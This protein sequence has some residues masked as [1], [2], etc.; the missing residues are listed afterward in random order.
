MTAGSKT[1]MLEWLDTC[2]S[3]SKLLKERVKQGFSAPAAVAAGTQT[4]GVGRLGRFWISESGNLHLS[5]ALPPGVIDAKHLASLP[6]ICGVL[7]AEWIEST[8]ALSICIKWPNDLFLDGKKVGGILCEA[9]YEGAEF[10]GVILGIGINLMAVPKVS[11]LKSWDYLPGKLLWASGAKIAPR[12]IAF[13]LTDHFLKALH[14]LDFEDILRRRQRFSI[15]SGHQWIKSKGALTGSPRDQLP[16]E[17]LLDRG[18][19]GT[20][21]LR[22]EYGD[23]TPSNTGIILVNS[24]ANEYTW[25]IAKNGKSVVADV[26]NSMTKLAVAANDHQ[27][28]LDTV[29]VG[30]EAIE[31]LLKNFED[32]DKPAVIHAV[33]V[34]PEGLER[35]RSLAS[36]SGLTVREVQR[37][38]VALLKSKYDLQVIGMDRFAALEA[39]LNRQRMNRAHNPAMVVSLGTATTVDIIDSFGCHLGGYIV[40]GPQ[41]ALEAVSRRGRNL[42]KDLRISDAFSSPESAELY[43]TSSAQAMIDGTAQMM[44]SFL[45]GE[46]AKLAKHCGVDVHQVHVSLTGGFSESFIKI[47]SD[48]GVQADP[49]LTL[50]GVAVLSFNGR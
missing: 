3:T 33:S 5:I 29:A 48:P 15:Q 27:I 17:A 18:V 23:G 6:I 50:I 7:V 25:A 14:R 21:Q 36:A 10:R 13:R 34:N 16:Y 32:S 39:F 9:T 38:P 4:A 41:T 49:N 47:W 20:G 22:L 30:D 2:E 11:D 26:G 45:K 12:D 31:R 35:L 19:D 46:R 43:P 28:K 40:A 44:L 24:V 1:L 42:P 37:Q 8:F